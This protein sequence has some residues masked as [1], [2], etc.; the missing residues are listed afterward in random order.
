ARPAS[1][2]STIS[3]ARIRSL[4]LFS[5]SQTA[6]LDRL[7]CSARLCFSCTCH[8]Q[9]THPPSPAIH[10]SVTNRGIQ[11]LREWRVERS[12]SRRPQRHCWLAVISVRVAD[13][14]EVPQE[15]CNIFNLTPEL[16]HGVGVTG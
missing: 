12:S 14:E 8:G 9:P 2:R 11:G 7:T 10:V 15:A 3:Q 13:Y 4:R 16:R 1:P 5:T 6:R